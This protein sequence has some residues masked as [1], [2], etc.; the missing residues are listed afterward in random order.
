MKGVEIMKKQLVSVLTAVFLTFIA[1]QNMAL[2]TVDVLRV[3][4]GYIVQILGA[5]TTITTE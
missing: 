1:T 3:S 2:S 5:E 4:D